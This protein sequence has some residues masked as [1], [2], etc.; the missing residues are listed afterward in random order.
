MCRTYRLSQEFITPYTPE[1]NGMIERFFRSLKEEC[2]WQHNFGSF[3]EAKRNIDRWMTWYNTGRLHQGV[4]LHEPARIQTAATTVGGLT[5]GKQ[6]RS[7]HSDNQ[8]ARLW[9]ETSGW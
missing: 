1:Q 6:Y 7:T 2:T 5:T 8:P 3:G 4:E 9:I